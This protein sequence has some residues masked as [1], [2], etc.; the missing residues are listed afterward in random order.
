[1]GRFNK[2]VPLDDSPHS[3][4]T[5]LR[6]MFGRI[7]DAEVAAAEEEDE[8]EE[9]S[10]VDYPSFGSS[11]DGEQAARQFYGRWQNFSTRLSFAWRDR[12]RLSDAPDRRVRRLMEKEN[13]KAREDA[14]RE[15]ND[16]VRSLVVFVRKRDPRHVANTQSEAERQ[17]VLRD[18]AAAQAARSRAAHLRKMNLDNGGAAGGEGAHEDAVPEWA[19]SRDPD[20][21]DPHAGEFSE[22]E[23]EESEVEHIECVVCGKTFKSEKQ[24]EAHEKSKKHLKAVQ[25]LRR[26]MRKENAHLALD[27]DGDD[28]G[29]DDNDGASGP[30]PAPTDG[31]TGDDKRED[32]PENGINEEVSPKPDAETPEP[33]SSKVPIVDS[34]TSDEDEEDD[35]YASRDAVE[36]RLAGG[37]RQRNANPFS[38]GDDDDKEEEKGDEETDA[39]A[40]KVGDVSI[41]EEDGDAPPQKKLGK[42]KAKRE[43]KAAAARQAAAM[44]SSG[45]HVRPPPPSSLP[46]HLLIYS[47]KPGMRFHLTDGWLSQKCT[48]CDATFDSK[49]KLFR[50]LD[51]NPKHTALKAAT[52]SSS[53]SGGKKKKK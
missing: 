4:F 46:R 29:G 38:I 52:P 41:T 7:A 48:G 35:D 28:G 44:N 8:Y 34:G 42:A 11:G 9:G 18:A 3:F 10:S 12:W 6:E 27:E 21:K 2:N 25:Q 49:T 1:M 20:E 32:A 14:A 50:H 26:Q 37:P 17:R 45:V 40:A 24:Y 47:V 5:I 39:L 22:S 23:S 16:A 36:A 43:K 31:P 19:R 53:K 15:F 13:R 33:T 30:P 51:E